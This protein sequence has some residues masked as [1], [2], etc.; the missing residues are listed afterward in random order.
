[1]KASSDVSLLR[2]YFLYTSL[3]GIRLGENDDSQLRITHL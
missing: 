1:M 3:R 2:R